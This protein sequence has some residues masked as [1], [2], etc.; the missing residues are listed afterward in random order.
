MSWEY[1]LAKAM[2]D[3]PAKASTEGAMIG[4][5]I[6]VEPVKVQIQDGQFI[7]DPDNCYVCS[8]LMERKS[9]FIAKEI[10]HKMSDDGTQ[11]GG[12]FDWVNVY[13]EG[14][15]ELK[16]MWKP[17]D[18][19]LVVPDATGQKFFIVDKIMEG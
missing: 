11:N 10:M 18:K 2:K 4:I 3:K 9:D 19:V 12:V 7:L 6:S 17:G 13:L 14:K 8:H 15:M 16:E 1:T 5:T